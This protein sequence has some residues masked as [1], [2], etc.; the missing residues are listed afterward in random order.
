ML[1][2]FHRF[3]VFV[4]TVEN[5]SNTLRCTCGHIHFRK[6]RKKYPDACRTEPKT[7]GPAWYSTKIWVQASRGGFKALLANPVYD[8]KN[9]EISLPRL[10]EHTQFC[11]SVQDKGQNASRFLLKQFIGNCNGANSRQSHC[12][13]VIGVYMYANRPCHGFRHHLDE[14]ANT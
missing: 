2:Y 9:P 4:W 8:K 12:F 7:S 11:Y 1:S 5:D 14:Q 3:S 13:C 10:G 6:R